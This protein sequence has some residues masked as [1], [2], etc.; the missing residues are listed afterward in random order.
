MAHKSGAKIATRIADLVSKSIVSTHAGLTGIK[1]KLAMA[2]FHSISDVISA[3][4]HQTM[5]PIF[6]A[7]LSSDSG[8]GMASDALK[9]LAYETGQLQA[10]S[11]ANILSQSILGS[12]ATIVNNELAPV[13]QGIVSSNPH[14]LP[15][16]GTLAAMAARGIISVDQADDN[17]G[18]NG[19]ASTWTDTL[20]QLNQVAPDVSTCL[21]L[22]RRNLISAS[23]F[24]L[25]AHTNGIPTQMGEILVSLADNPLSPADA[26]LAY[27]RGNLSEGD[28]QAAAAQSGVSADT[29]TTLVNNT[30]EPLGLEQ[31]LE[32][33]RRGFIDQG[34][35]EQ[36]ILQSRVRNEWIPTALALAYSP[37]SVADAVNAVVQN[38]LDQGTAET[39]AQQNGLMPGMFDILL[40]TAGE[41][42]SRTEMEE[43]YNRGLVTE[44]QVTQALSESRLK[45]KYNDLAF[46]LHTRLLQ[47]S[48]L[49]DAVLY[50][51][52]SESD[53]VAAALNLGYSEQGATT[54]VLAASNAKM[55][56]YR[57]K[58][59]DNIASLYEVNAMDQ[60]T[61]AGLITGMGWSSEQANVILE[62]AEFN[63]EKRLQEAAIT[64]IRSKYIGYHITL[65]VV[66]TD[67]TQIGVPAG[68]IDY[69]TQLW[70]LEQSANVPHMSA[71]DVAKAVSAGLMDQPT[72]VAYL[73]AIGYTLSDATILSQVAG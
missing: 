60:T 24:V 55:L 33:Y 47:P 25:F 8:T 73:Q 64:G 63:R 3:E 69:L 21:E 41:P 14:G 39:Y 29:F 15:D 27:L 26:A 32:A 72:A 44:S 28:A 17:I 53:A 11:G 31:L 58:V 38:Q 16:V 54:L 51:A 19:I 20:V 23:D 62:S 59:V 56:A 6:S 45:N 12:V 67:L 18:K 10:L 71:Y 34:T 2:V 30:G 9:F 13:V 66:R 37:M 48:S 49:S 7:L 70:T 4:V 22:Y 61:A 1:H 65:D 57:T 40:A 35:L 42:L 52:M 50:G 36:G 5:D 43:L 46:E 68:E